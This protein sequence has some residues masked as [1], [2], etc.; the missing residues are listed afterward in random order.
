MYNTNFNV[1]YHDIRFELLTNLNK[2]EKQLKENKTVHEIDYKYNE[3]DIDIICNKLYRDELLSVFYAN[4]IMD[5]IIDIN[6]RKL[7]NN[8]MLDNSFK[9]FIMDIVSE[10][11]NTSHY[12][13]DDK[14]IIF[15][16]L[17]KE[18]IF[19]LS[20]KLNCEFINNKNINL[21][22]LVIIKQK[23]LELLK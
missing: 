23:T 2:R 18:E 10:L 13:D 6:M 20:H 3:E 21:D 14:Y 22:L 12:E 1:K 15:M 19:Y 8:F 16:S 11:T 9:Q 5:D 7:F 4:D 17:F